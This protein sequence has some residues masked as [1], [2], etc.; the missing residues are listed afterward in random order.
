MFSD[1]E[2]EIK[3][4]LKVVKD[5]V[6]AKELQD[7]DSRRVHLLLVLNTDFSVTQLIEADENY[8]H[9][10]GTIPQLSPYLYLTITKHLKWNKFMGEVILHCPE[11]LSVD[12]LKCI[13]THINVVEVGNLV[14]FLRSLYDYLFQKIVLLAECESLHKKYKFVKIF[15]QV[16][17]IPVKDILDQNELYQ[18]KRYEI[19]INF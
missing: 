5:L 10:L 15:Q 17:A 11:A 6:V 19:F 12:L 13:D 7:K 4:I 16:L 18:E 3:E 2:V 8:C 9:L 14:S 1:N